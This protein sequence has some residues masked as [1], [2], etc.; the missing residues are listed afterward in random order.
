MLNPETTSTESDNTLDGLAHECTNPDCHVTDFI[1]TYKLRRM[2]GE[3]ELPLKD[4]LKA[5]ESAVNDMVSVTNQQNNL[6]ND[7]S[8]AI[9]PAIEGLKNSPLGTM[10]GIK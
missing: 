8:G 7:I 6:L 10:F 5:L 4:R 3:V 1:L 2:N 9:A